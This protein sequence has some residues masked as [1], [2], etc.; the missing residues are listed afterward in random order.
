[1]YK[2]KFEFNNNII[3]V[4]HDGD[5]LYKTASV[6]SEYFKIPIS[7]LKWSCSDSKKLIVTLGDEWNTILV[8][9][10]VSTRKVRK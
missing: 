9:Y 1:M 8:V 3:T 5:L 10:F 2:T 6:L 7:T 4:V